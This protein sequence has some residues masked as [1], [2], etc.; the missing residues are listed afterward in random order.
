MDLTISTGQSRKSLN[1]TPETLTWEAL[2]KRLTTVTRTNET[3]AEWNAMSPDQRSAAKDVGGYVGG[4]LTGER[5]KADAV[6]TRCLIVL[7]A[8]YAPRDFKAAVTDAFTLLAAALCAH[9]THSHTP[10][11]PRWRLVIP[12]TRAVTADEYEACARALSAEIGMELFDDTTYEPARL[13]YWPSCPKDGVFESWQQEG[14][15]CNPDA[16]LAR[17][18]DWRDASSWPRSERSKRL[19]AEAGR[20][21][22]DPTAKPGIVGAF[23]RVYDVPAAIDKF[24]PGVYEEAGAGR[25]TFAAGSTSGGM[26]LMDEGA[27]CR[28]YHS[29]DP[30]GGK[31]INA[32]DLTRLHLYGALDDDADEDTP[33]NQLPS[34]QAMRALC[35]SDA[36][37]WLEL[38]GTLPEDDFASADADERELTSQ[39]VGSDQDVALEF[40]DFAWPTLRYSKALGWCAWDGR[41]WIPDADSRA[42]KMVMAFNDTILALARTESGEDAKNKMKRA[43]ALRSTGKIGGLLINAQA[44]LSDNDDWDTDPWKLNTPEGIIHLKDGT[45]HAHD[46]SE[47]MTAI[48]RVSPERTDAPMWTRFLQQATGGDKGLE[49]YLQQV[50]GMALVGKVYSEG[51]LIVTG[52]GGNGKSTLFGACMKV[53]GSYAETIRPEIL[54]ARP[55]GGEVFGIE[56]MRGKRLC[57]AGETDEHAGMSVSMMKR[58]TS[59]DTINA[60]PKHKQPFNFTPSHTLIL[61][62]NHLPNIKQFDEGTKRRLAVAVFPY[63]PRPEE[64]IVDLMDQLVEKEGG[65]ILQWMIDG[66]ARYWKQGCQL[67]VPSSVR[68]HT[69]Q[70]LEANDWMNQFLADCCE[71]GADKSC[72]GGVLYAR[73]RAWCAEVGERYPKRSRDFANELLSRGFEKQRV[74][75]GSEWRGLAVASEFMD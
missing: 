50:L 8:D 61:H 7:D 17:Y 51:L 43:V 21:Q 42:R 23:C 49:D 41:R 52:S 4:R 73:Y 22:G 26:I 65:A 18:A 15:F 1:W 68:E 74:R 35:R 31:L 54:L 75:G 19:L 72:K 38:G 39:G 53:L 37:V 30:A 20:R 5:R 29:T 10:E 64:I 55:N 28:S 62:T 33:I 63:A 44:L 34:Y 27:F 67:R 25:Y 16:I 14:D 3:Q 57:I 47:R 9:T 2:C 40:R 45:L 60:N 24:L 58:L 56:C 12:L 46:P 66:A 36:A 11:K 71:L 70:Y 13:M 69:R 6:K 32:F 59:R 48:T